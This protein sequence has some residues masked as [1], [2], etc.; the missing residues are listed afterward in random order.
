MPNNKL[1]KEQFKIKFLKEKLEKLTGKKVMLENFEDEVP[2]QSNP[3]QPKVKQQPDL[4]GA[5]PIEKL[6][7]GSI[8]NFPGKTSEYYFDGYNRSTG[9]YSYHRADDISA[10]GEKKKGTLVIP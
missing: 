10:F 7:K 9:K 8:F 5:V 6:K 3:I 2:L 1:T 4:T